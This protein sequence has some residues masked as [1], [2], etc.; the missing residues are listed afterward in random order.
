MTEAEALASLVAEAGYETISVEARSALKIRVLD[1]LG[2]AI[3]ALDAPLMAQ[4]RGTMYEL[5]GKALATAI[6][7][8]KTALDRAA[9]YNSALVRYLDFNDSFLAKNETCHPSDNLGAVLAASEYAGA[10]GKEFLTA[11]AVAY[12]V[13]CRLCEAAPVRA[14]GFDHTTQGAYAL[15]AGVSKALGLTREQ[16][17]NAIAISGTANNALRVTRTGR[18]SNWKGLAYANTALSVVHTC[19]LAQAGVTGPLEVFEG[20]KGF[21]QAIAGDF[22]VN[23]AK[24]DLEA[25]RRTMVKKYNSEMH[26]QSAVEGM[27]ELRERHHIQADTVESIEVEIFEVGYNIIGGGEEGERKEVVTKEDAD[28]SLPYILAV[29]LLDGEVGPSQYT[30]ERITRED[31]QTLLRKIRVR[32]NASFSAR[33]PDDM[34]V[35]IQINIRDGR[36]IE[37][38]KHDYEGFPTRPMSWQK[39]VGKF[40][41]LTEPRMNE[42]LRTAM[43]EAIEH[44]EDRR[45]A[46][47][48]GLLG[49]TGIGKAA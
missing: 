32:P 22:S 27:I 26:S 21:K 18:L 45:I 4:L 5:G 42:E 28:H 39:V 25:V 19:I 8:G 35:K 41:S 29:A 3:G 17:A 15:A 48:T 13:Q 24:E 47:L 9:F 44:L 23:W 14:K 43:I 37:T 46:K 33:F 49:R 1:A 40:E 31:A 6:G 12:Q 16:T 7:N 34:S 11:L 30:A 10:S 38:E 20:T 36:R 2:C